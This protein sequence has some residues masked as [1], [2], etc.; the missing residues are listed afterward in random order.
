MKS[1]EDKL[2]ASLKSFETK[3]LEQSLKETDELFRNPNLLIESI[4][5]MQRQQEETIAEL[6]S[7][8]DEQSQVKNDLVQMNEFKQNLSFNQDPFG[9]VYLS[10]Y[11][12]NGLIKSQILSGIQPSELI[13][14]CEFSS[15]DK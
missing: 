12:G 11:S 1:L 14:L 7:N 8:L 2:E 3:S 9:L 6:K 5:E 4:Q 13:N 15:K 10:E